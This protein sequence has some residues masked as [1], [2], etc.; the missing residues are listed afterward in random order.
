MVAARGDHRAAGNRD[1]AATAR[2]ISATRSDAG[3][4]IVASRLYPAGRRNYNVSA[5][6]MVCRAYAGS[7]VF[8]RSRH[9]GV[10]GNSDVPAGSVRAGGA[11]AR[12]TIDGGGSGDVRVAGNGDVAA[13]S[14]ISRRADADATIDDNRAALDYDVA[15][16]EY[17]VG[18]I[19]IGECAY[20]RTPEFRAGR[21]GVQ[22]PGASDCQ[23]AVRRYVDG[24]ACTVIC[25]STSDRV[26]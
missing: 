3:R 19:R 18:I 21:V 26:F 11:D 16:G 5:W 1:V 13:I 15:T 20:R 22:R 8:S 10:A 17:I 7:V 2:L 24:I 23:G 6:R 14:A 9:A 12:R 25:D 4:K